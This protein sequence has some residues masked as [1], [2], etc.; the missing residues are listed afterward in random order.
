MSCGTGLNP[1][2]GV[3]LHLM[4]ET[5]DVDFQIQAKIGL[6]VLLKRLTLIQKIAR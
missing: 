2:W 1:A 5:R 4:A 6:V 3:K